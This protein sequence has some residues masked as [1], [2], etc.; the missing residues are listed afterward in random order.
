MNL[1]EAVN[2][3]DHVR[4]ECFS[5]KNVETKLAV[6]INLLTIN[7]ALQVLINNAKEDLLDGNGLGDK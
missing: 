5:L 1:S 2:I 3:L 4:L 6:Q 7:K